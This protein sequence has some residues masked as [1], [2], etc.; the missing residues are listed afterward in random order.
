MAGKPIDKVKNPKK[1]AAWRVNQQRQSRVHHRAGR[2]A[3]SVCAIVLQLKGYRILA[4]NWRS[5]QG[6]IDIIAMRFGVLVFCEVK[7][8]P[9][10]AA[11]QQA[12]GPRQWQRISAAASAFCAKRPHLA[13][14]RWR[15]DL[16]ACTPRQ[17]PKHIEDV[18]RA[19]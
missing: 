17:W 5:P 1:A 9:I 10:L 8:R 14:H 12:A 19:R 11:A 16:M 18:W 13:K 6:E 7:Y 15:F 4:R 2:R 3:E